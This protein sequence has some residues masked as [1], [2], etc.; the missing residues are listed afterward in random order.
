M[1]HPAALVELVVARGARVLVGIILARR[2]A[3]EHLRAGMLVQEL[4]EAPPG[5]AGL[6]GV[7][8]D[9]VGE[10]LRSH[11]EERRGGC[12]GREGVLRYIDEDG[13]LLALV[14]ELELLVRVDVGLAYKHVELAL[15]DFLIATADD[16]GGY[17]G[18]DEQ[19]REAADCGYARLGVPALRAA[20]TQ[21]G[22]EAEQREVAGPDP[23]RAAEGAGVLVP[24]HEPGGTGEGVAQHEPG[25]GYLR[26]EIRSL[27]GYPSSGQEDVGERTSKLFLGKAEQSEDQRHLE[28]VGQDGEDA[29]ADR[30]P[31]YPKRGECVPKDESTVMP[32]PEAPDAGGGSTAFH[33]QQG[34]EAEQCQEACMGD[35]P[36]QAHHYSKGQRKRRQ[37]LIVSGHFFSVNGL[38]QI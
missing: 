16:G 18:A 30:G 21:G 2:G 27:P 23:E 8:D 24:L 36:R 33:L 1:L 7:D 6:V 19:Q 22:D 9:V 37:G 3:E 4:N 31:A 35:E 13:V 11:Y 26:A 29:A 5:G 32:G 10:S 15:G 14:K 20:L 25:P 38:E 17:R 28:G 12:P 34:D